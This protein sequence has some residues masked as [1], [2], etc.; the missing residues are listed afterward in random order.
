MLPTPLLEALLAGDVQR[1]R[2]LRGGVRGDEPVVARPEALP[3]DEAPHG[4]GGA[5]GLRK[6]A[7]ALLRHVVARLKTRGA[8]T[9]VVDGEPLAILAAGDGVHLGDH[10]HEEPQQGSGVDVAQLALPLAPLVRFG[11]EEAER[12][13]RDDGVVRQVTHAQRP[14]SVTVDR[15][16]QHI[17]GLVRHNVVD[18]VLLGQLLS[19]IVAHGGA[20]VEVHDEVHGRCGGGAA[21]AVHVRHGVREGPRGRPVAEHRRGQGRVGA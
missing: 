14:A 9:D 1:G 12:A 8:H 2:A 6:G 10:V 15:L 18:C 3:A 13:D 5:E 4:D 16:Q 11:L 7:R 20:P 21:V 19:D 17:A